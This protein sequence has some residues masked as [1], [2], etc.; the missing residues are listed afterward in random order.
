LRFFAKALSHDCREPQA[1]R[2]VDKD[3][4]NFCD[5]FRFRDS[6]AGEEKPGTEAK[7]KLEE[8]FRK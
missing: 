1:E 7:K 3:R 2:I 4:S 8:L 6:A 5:Y